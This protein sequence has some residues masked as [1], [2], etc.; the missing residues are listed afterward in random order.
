MAI[1]NY[2]L[3]QTPSR[4]PFHPINVKTEESKLRCRKMNHDVIENGE[5]EI[6]ARFFDIIKCKHIYVS[7]L[8][9]ESFPPQSANFLID[10][11]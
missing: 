5:K 11:K 1:Y 4:S 2:M 7:F 6:F 10:L 9:M 8:T 3:R